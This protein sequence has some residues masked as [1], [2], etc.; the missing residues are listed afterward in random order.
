[1]QGCVITV[2]RAA[3]KCDMHADEK[4]KRWI[5]YERCSK[6]QMI[7]AGWM[8]GSHEQELKVT[9]RVLSILDWAPIF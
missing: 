6:I 8:E 3:K 9:N 4:T 5:K 7:F 1:M 2:Q